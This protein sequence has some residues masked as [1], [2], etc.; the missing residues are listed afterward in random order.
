MLNF[1]DLRFTETPAVVKGSNSLGQ[2]I[3]H[4][5]PKKTNN[6]KQLA[7]VSIIYPLSCFHFGPYFPHSH[8]YHK[9]YPND[10]LSEVV[11]YWCLEILVQIQP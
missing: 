7:M 5:T 6:N 10:N 2:Y 3:K 4:S 1:A 11:P 8:H 9:S